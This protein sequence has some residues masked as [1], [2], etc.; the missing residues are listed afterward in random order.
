MQ[1]PQSSQSFWTIFGGAYAQTFNTLVTVCDKVVYNH[2][3]FAPGYER[4]KS[5][6]HQQMCTSRNSSLSTA[7]SISSLIMRSVRN[8][9]I[10]GT[11]F[12]DKLVLIAKNTYFGKF[13]TPRPPSPSPSSPPSFRTKSQKNFFLAASLVK[14]CI[15]I[16]RGGMKCFRTCVAKIF[17]LRYG[18][19][20]PQAQSPMEVGMSL[21]I[22]NC[23]LLIWNGRV[24]EIKDRGDHVRGT[25]DIFRGQKRLL[26]KIIRGGRTSF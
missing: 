21:K 10:T 4:Q 2:C 9:W 24:L 17:T 26:I 5:G 16:G 7:A 3:N 22:Y 1:W 23:K 20:F 18:R 19:H 15:R 11:H 25:K 12:G 14:I 6:C 13:R 8:S